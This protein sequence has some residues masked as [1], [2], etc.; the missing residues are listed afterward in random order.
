M[1]ESDD[2]GWLEMLLGFAM[3]AAALGGVVFVVGLFVG[4]SLAR[5][6]LR[7]HLLAAVVA[8]P[9]F[10]LAIATDHDENARSGTLAAAVSYAMYM[11]VVAVVVGLTSSLHDI[12]DWPDTVLGA[13][14]ASELLAVVAGVSYGV[15]TSL[16]RAL[17]GLWGALAWLVRA[18][19]V[20]VGGAVS[21]IRSGSG[22]ATAGSGDDVSRVPPSESEPSSVPN[23]TVGPDAEDLADG[24]ATDVERALAIG[25][26]EVGVH[27]G[28]GPDARE[29]DFGVKVDGRMTDGRSVT[30]AT[31]SLDT[32]LD[33]VVDDL[34]DALQA[35]WTV[36]THPNVVELVE[37]GEDIRPWYVYEVAEG[38]NYTRVREDLTAANHLSVAVDVCEALGALQRYNRQ[39]H[40]LDPGGVIV[41]AAD[42]PGGVVLDWGIRDALRR[43]TDGDVVTAFDAPEQV[44]SDRFGPPGTATTVYRVAGIVYW[45]LCGRPPVASDDLRTAIVEDEV[46]P[47]SEVATGLPEGVDDV[48]GQALATHPD[49]RYDDIRS[50]RRAL[51][52]LSVD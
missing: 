17:G 35:W 46:R 37:W 2:D 42:Q 43:G 23:D 4:G 50:F 6:G 11:V 39:H 18:P 8:A 33:A 22:S 45:G 5:T 19:V 32:D 24:A 7:I 14:V 44:D 21:R 16:P 25:A 51:K 12:P 36:R 34:T 15:V 9:I 1:S 28:R 3:L 13:A 20:A 10:A 41:A 31:P 26:P 47:P 27:V 30:V 49:D 29:T 52:R 40:T 48:L 38:S